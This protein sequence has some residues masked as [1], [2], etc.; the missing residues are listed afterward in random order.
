MTISKQS[1]ILKGSNQH[2]VFLA[3]GSNIGNSYEILNQA[4]FYFQESGMLDI[5]KVSSFYLTEPWGITNQNWFYNL[6]I[7]AAT[8]CSQYEL[9]TFAK[10]IEIYLGRLHRPKWQE[11]EIDID[12]LFYENLILQN[13]KI[14]IPHPQIENRK[15]VLVP[16]AE[17]A[18]KFV[19]PILNLSIHE[20]LL[21]CKDT[22]RVIRKDEI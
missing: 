15:F 6:V 4:I 21:N 9:I 18:P 11:R 22:S 14:T 20:I 8:D 5:I 10:T 13:P 1:N 16:M 19:H 17:I 12:L 3:L 2:L 7:E